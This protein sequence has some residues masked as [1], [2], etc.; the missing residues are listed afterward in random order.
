MDKQVNS[1]NAQH[2]YWAKLADKDS[3]P[4]QKPKSGPTE[5]AFWTST[6]ELRPALTEQYLHSITLENRTLGLVII[7][8]ISFRS[9]HQISFKEVLKLALDANVKISS[10]HLYVRQLWIAVVRN[11]SRTS[12][13]MISTPM[14]KLHR[15][16]RT[17]TTSRTLRFKRPS[18]TRY[19]VVVKQTFTLC[20]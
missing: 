15:S 13:V 14:S 6:R 9:I 3:I 17:H 7:P 12:T 18:S 19:A 4:R 11:I 2:I 8:S 16:M 10:L 5:P 1:L 20:Q